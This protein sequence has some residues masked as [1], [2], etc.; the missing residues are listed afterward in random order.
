M[1]KSDSNQSR[2]KEKKK[3]WRAVIRSVFGIMSNI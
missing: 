3:N 2:K 1:G